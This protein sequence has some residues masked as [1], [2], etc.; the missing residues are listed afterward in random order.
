MAPSTR[1]A[2]TFPKENQSLD[3]SAYRFADFVLLP[4]ERMLTRADIPVSIQ[5]KTFDALLLL[6][7]HAGHLVSKTELMRSLW[8]D[9]H[10][11]E[12]NLTNVIVSLRKLL[13]RESIRTV[14][15]HGYR[16]DL[17]ILCEPGVDRNTYE[18][19][20]Q[21]RTIIRTRSLEEMPRA[22]DLLSLCIAKSPTFAQGWAWLGRSCLFLDKFSK[23]SSLNVDIAQASLER[24]LILQPDLTDAHAFLTLYEVDSGRA[25]EAIIRLAKQLTS[26]PKQP[27]LY[28]GLVHALRFRGLLAE[29]LHADQ[30]A[31]E[32]DPSTPTSVAHTLFLIGDFAGCIEAYS[33]RTPYYLDAAAWAALGMYDRAAS[34]LQR[35]VA[36]LPLSSLLRALLESLFYAITGEPTKALKAM[37]SA[38][39]RCEP[40]ILIYFARHLSYL[41]K[42]EEAVRALEAAADLGFISAPE[43]LRNDPWLTS[44]RQTPKYQP[45]LD[46]AVSNAQNTRT[47]YQRVPTTG[48]A[49]L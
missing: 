19:F 21:A 27:D 23:S 41:N 29:S 15:K 12:A 31:R 44:I 39:L 18:F 42:G 10:V 47:K 30:C 35:R 34:L 45:L 8:P 1:M 22:R 9:T 25:A 32:L 43:M 26:R 3:G 11:K 6:V 40:E 46:V 33:G 28:A 24:A 37:E 4:S 20:L 13:G 38:S 36:T 7:L 14:S 5:P 48:S 16:F 49:T 17:P 2:L